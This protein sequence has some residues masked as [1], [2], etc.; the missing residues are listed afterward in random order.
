MENHD[1]IE[2][3]VTPAHGA[4]DL[5]ARAPPGYNAGQGNGPVHGTFKT[6]SFNLAKSQS[7]NGKVQNPTIYQSSVNQ[8]FIDKIYKRIYLHN[9]KGK[10]G[11]M[12]FAFGGTAGG[13]SNNFISNHKV[14]YKDF[15]TYV[16]DCKKHLRMADDI[17]N[18][19]IQQNIQPVASF[20]IQPER[21]KPSLLTL[22]SPIRQEEEN[23]PFGSG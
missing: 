6:D 14:D 16:D 7:A 17:R 22:L 1:Y 10:V 9:L 12:P 8:P 13:P 4:K 15:G 21:C 2:A 19:K 5:P 18:T 20:D 23:P 11:K 3:P